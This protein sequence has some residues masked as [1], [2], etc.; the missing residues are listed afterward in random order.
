MSSRHAH[1]TPS[2]DPGHAHAHDQN[3]G[4]AAPA[5]P[6]AGC[7]T[8][9][10]D[11]AVDAPTGQPGHPDARNGAMQTPIRIMQMDR[12][13]EEALLRGTLGGMAGVAGME[14]NLMQRV[15]TVTHDPDAIEPILQAVRSLGFAPEITSAPLALAGAAAFGAEATQGPACPRGWARCWP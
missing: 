14:F 10:C 4:S 8:A 7:A 6:K 11:H 9:C 2:H 15:L 5:P 3:S 13:T 1:G 12:P